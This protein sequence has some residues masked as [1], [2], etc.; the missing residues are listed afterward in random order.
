MFKSR[1]ERS[2]K[3][4]EF[5][6]Q[7]TEQAHKDKCDVNKIVKRYQRSGMPIPPLDITKFGDQPSQSLHE[8]MNMILEAKQTFDALPSTVR[9]KFEN[10]PGGFLDFAADPKNATELEAIMKGKEYVP[11]RVEAEVQESLNPAAT[12]EATPQETA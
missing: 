12:P 1:Y 5:P 7:L 2:V 6:E 9:A 11:E 10:N 4:K 3:I 8:S